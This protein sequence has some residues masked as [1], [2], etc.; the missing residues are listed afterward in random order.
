ML[1]LIPEREKAGLALLILGFLLTL[2]LYWRF[3]T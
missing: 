3:A 1:E 2:Y